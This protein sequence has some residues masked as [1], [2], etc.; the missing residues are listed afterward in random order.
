MIAFQTPPGPEP[1]PTPPVPLCAR[2]HVRC[3]DLVM[4]RPYGFRLIRTP[5][6]RSL[7]ASTNAIVNIGTGPLE[8]RARHVPGHQ[9][10]R[11]RQIVRGTT[12]AATRVLPP[13]GWVDY[14]DTHTRGRYW[15]FGHAAAF[16][17]WSVDATGHPRELVRT[18]PKIYYCF[19][20]RRRL[21]RLDTHRPYAGSPRW[22]HFGACSTTRVV[23][24]L[25][26]GTSVG[27]A[28]IYPS[29]YPQNAIDVTGLRGCFLYA[30]VADPTN[31]LV[32]SDE[33]NNAKARM[34]R[35]PW[36]GVGRHGCPVGKAL[37][38]VVSQPPA[39]EGG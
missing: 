25:T 34:I 22:P 10:L 15:K 27:W 17:L 3:P 37:P 35:L 2:P 14:Y 20:D 8:I 36:R 16:E 21:I 30:H 11:T 32:E 13:T 28:D 18:G 5:K 4:R 19:R 31:A 38:P 9:E 33:T 12:R 29:T 39:G 26:L 7:L 24:R 23:R 6:G 1:T